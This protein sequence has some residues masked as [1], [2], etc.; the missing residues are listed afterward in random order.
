ML[1]W[2]FATGIPPSHEFIW[3]SKRNCYSIHNAYWLLII[4]MSIDVSW[5][6]QCCKLVIGVVPITDTTLFLHHIFLMGSI[7]S[8]VV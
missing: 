3:D 6:K 1:F 8:V 4:I 2:K 7:V 5:M